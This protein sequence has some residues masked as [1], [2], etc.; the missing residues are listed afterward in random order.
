VLHALPYFLFSVQ[1]WLNRPVGDTTLIYAIGGS[2]SLTW[3][4]SPEWFFVFSLSARCM[5]HPALLGAAINDSSCAGMTG[6]SVKFA[7]LWM[8]LRRR[9]LMCAG[10][11]ISHPIC[12]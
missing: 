5:A 3:S 8:T 7:S 9:I 6:R 2:S 12:A 1:S 4:I 11:S 10:Y